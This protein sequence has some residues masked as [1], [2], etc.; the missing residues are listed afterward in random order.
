MGADWVV[1]FFD[2]EL[3]AASGVRV[4]AGRGGTADATDLPILREPSGLP[5]IPGSSMKGVLRSAAERLLRR[6]DESLACD[7][8]SPTHC[9]AGRTVVDSVGLATLCWTCQV[10]G[11]PAKAGRLAVYDLV[12]DRA[13]TVVRDGVA[14]DRAE[15][16]AKPGAK[17]DYEVVPPGV[18]FRSRLR[19]D[20]P[21]PGDM[22][23]IIT[24][25]DLLDAGVITVGGGASRGLGQLR[26]RMPPRI[27]RLRASTF[28]TDVGDSPVD[29]DA[30]RSAFNARLGGGA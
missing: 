24:L 21:E 29:I 28:H 2:L 4:G 14:I 12:A 30:E 5:I 6:V 20:D 13:D 16:K 3:Q 17:Y 1:A 19:L 18:V 15:L 26:Y 27:T 11:N 9:L 7:I 23:L 25:L 22:G 10:F 8:L